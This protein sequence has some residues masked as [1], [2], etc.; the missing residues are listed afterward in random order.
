[1][2]P[3]SNYKPKGKKKK[4]KGL[5]EVKLGISYSGREDRYS[6]GKSKETYPPI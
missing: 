5:L 3:L 4:D 2:L 1:M 6:T